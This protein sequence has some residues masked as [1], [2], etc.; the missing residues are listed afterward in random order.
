[1]TATHSQDNPPA[2]QIIAQ[3]SEFGTATRPGRTADGES[4][5]LFAKL[6]WRLTEGSLEDW[7]HN[8]QMTG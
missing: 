2:V 6:S 8:H 3:S 1:M 5:A 7:G 4:R